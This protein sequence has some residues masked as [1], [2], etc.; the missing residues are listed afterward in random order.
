[1]TTVIVP[2]PAVSDLPAISPAEPDP[3]IEKGSGAGG[4]S[5]RH[6]WWRRPGRPL[7]S[8]PARAAIFGMAALLYCWDLARVGMGN[9]FYAAAVK[10]GTESWKAFFFGSLDPGSF[11]TVDKPPAALWVMEL[12]GRIFGF[13]SWSMLLPEALAGVATVMVLYHLVRRWFGEPAAVFASLALA[14]TPVA[15]VIFRY[16]DPDA[17]LTFLLV[18]AAWACWRA[19][20]TGKTIGLVLSGALIGLA[21]LTK[22]LDAFIVVP[23]IGVAYLWCGPPRLARRLGQLG[24]AALALLVSSGWWVA[25]VELWP[26]SARPYIGGS[27]D[28]SEL[29][30]IFGYNGFSRIFG[31][32]GGAGSAGGATSGG[33]SAFGGG[34][35]LLRMFDSELGGQ[36]S[37]LLPVA[38][39][40]L[41]AGLWLTRRHARS[42]HQRA[43][44]VLWGG[45][46]LMYLAV[47]DYAKGI[48]HPYYTVVMAPAVAALA[49]AG[50]VAL[51]RLGR[52][53]LRW[54]WALPAAV[55]GTALWADALLARTSGYD[56]W[57]GPTVVVAGVLSAL[58]L[59][60][61]LARP[62]VPRWFAVAAGAVAAASLLAGPAAYSLTTLGTTTNG[63]ATA[64][65]T[66]A[67]GGMGS[68]GG[69]PG[70]RS[71]SSGA[72][73][74]AR[75]GGFPG[76]GTGTAGAP[77]GAHTG[78]G[79]TA[80]AGGGG[81]STANTA[82]VRY[83]ERHQGSAE[84]LVAVNGSQAAAPF[85]L[86]SGKAVIAMGGFTGTD[87]TPT[88]SEFEHLVSTGKVHYV[89][90]SSGGGGGGGASGVDGGGTSPG[91]AKTGTGVRTASTSTRT[92]LPSGRG[93]RSAGFSGTHG[94][95]QT[96]STT[97]AVDA[98]V[99]KHGTVVSSS[100]YGG[101]SGGG[102]LYY[103]SSSAA[104]K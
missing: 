44:F 7:W 81:A 72:P 6:Q 42:D 32:G 46:L 85:I 25:I 26:K 76:G 40:G 59:F 86:E 23:A 21:F 96:A 89:Y 19:I 45:T 39:A 17:L 5:E 20:E 83:L 31:S 73:T 1:M 4:A 18:L 37:W 50:A 74:G 91:A 33:S 100:A 15:V 95:G 88:L 98:W 9:S 38:L 64:G 92:R 82:L 68:G 3:E 8:V 53:S 51:W 75:T 58:V 87:P 35:G 43:G 61:C 66:S 103:V 104:T 28:N 48:F 71:G 56:S 14:L 99:E 10:S 65:P 101:S 30:L 80:A 90:V 36:I 41:V 22:T 34:E 62:Q 29:N 69:G 49:G 78:A 97:S 94:G 77:T 63:I 2:V 16:N 79:A 57:V 13:S 52:Q 54:A 55:V 70:G 27:T 84:Y 47:Y 60:L 102:T 11:I 12:S 93:G 24:W 67:G